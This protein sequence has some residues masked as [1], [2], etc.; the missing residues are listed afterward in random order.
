MRDI[1]IT[2]KQF[3]SVLL[4]HGWFA[5]KPFQVNVYPPSLVVPF[6]LPIGSGVLKVKGDRARSTLHALHGK[7]ENCALVS[8]HCLS[9]EVNL[10]GLYDLIDPADEEWGW[11]PLLRMGRFLRSPSLFEDCCKIILSTNTT[12]KRTVK[13]VNELVIRY[14]RRIGKYQAFP[15]PE[16]LL[17]VPEQELRA[18]TGC[19]FRARYLYALAEIA[20]NEKGI[21]LCDEWKSLSDRSFYETLV[22]VKGIGSASANYIS[23][24]Y[25]K[26]Q[27]FNIDAYVARR[28]K[29]L[30]GIG[31]HR[32]EPYLRKR[33]RKFKAFA[34]IVLWFDITRHWHSRKDI[35]DHRE[36]LQEI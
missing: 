8:N 21:F 35:L 16:T 18:V 6:D 15:R 12:W 14:G 24:L 13:M 17:D 10:D 34:P 23:L 1:R 30:W 32:I 31:D 25:W 22:S 19:G 28:C 11:L 2:G 7:L 33:Y 27:G 26:P 36:S 3:K 9:L 4:S 5:L 20:S 29:E